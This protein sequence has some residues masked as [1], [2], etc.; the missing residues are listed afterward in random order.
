MLAVTVLCLERGD[1]QHFQIWHS[2]LGHGCA[3][4]KGRKE[5]E[6]SLG[7]QRGYSGRKLQVESSLF[8]GG[9]QQSGRHGP[10]RTGAASGQSGLTGCILKPSAGPR[11]QR[12]GQ[13]GGL[14]EEMLGLLCHSFA[15]DI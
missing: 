13:A 1:R 7:P 11:G 8:P 2:A 15:V 6:A 5:P 14:S 3:G 9:G 10:K 4:G 12:S